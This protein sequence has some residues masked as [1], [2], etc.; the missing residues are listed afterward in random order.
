[1]QNQ[2]FPKA[3]SASFL[4]SEDCNL[5]CTY[6]FEEP[7]M[8]KDNMSWEAAKA[9]ID[10]LARNGKYDIM[11]FGGEPFLNFKLM[12]QMLEYSES[13][14]I[15]Y[16][17]SVVTNGT[18]MNSEI[19][20]WLAEQKEKIG[21]SVQ[22]SIDGPKHI[23][24]T[25]RVYRNGKGS[26]DKIEKN[27]P[28]FKRALG[29]DGN[30]HV[31]GCLNAKTIGSLY[32]SYK[33]FKEEWKIPW[34]WMMP[35]HGEDWAMSDVG[36]YHT[37]LNLIKDE[38]IGD[39]KRIGNVNP[40]RH[41]A[42][43]DKLLNMPTCHNK[44]CGAGSG[45]LSFNAKGEIWPCHEFYYNDPAKLMK[46]GDVFNGVNK[47]MLRVF[48]EYDH[49]DLGCPSECDAYGCYRCIADNFRM[50]GSIFANI[51]GARCLMSK[52]E[53]QVIKET[54]RELEEM[55]IFKKTVTTEIETNTDAIRDSV[56]DSQR[57]QI[58]PERMAILFNDILKRLDR[59]EKAQK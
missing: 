50:N 2:N 24:D 6:C 20:E 26:F 51:R 40:L 36:I 53:D 54:N 9:G 31:H 25:Y 41:Y 59:L 15:P 3:T 32:E 49:E 57:E 1:M 14:G 8:Y 43:I 39:I 47:E 44:P 13:L 29:L 11:F 19:E 10:L 35:I 38:I 30:L 58:N 52:V 5:A 42:P 27:L 34:I 55:G 37:Q 18:I 16:S 33:F 48:E 45:F 12:K 23:H 21:F 7:R 22:L 17:A 4:V 28:A 56:K 46:I